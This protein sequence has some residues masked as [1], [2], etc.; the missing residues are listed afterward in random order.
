[1]NF[2]KF[3]N[4]E[5]KEDPKILFFEVKLT[6]ISFRVKFT[7]WEYRSYRSANFSMCIQCITTFTGKKQTI[8]VT[9][10]ILSCLLKSA[11]A[12]ILSLVNH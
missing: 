1:M 7:F 11:S 8:S 4:L 6:E 10:K 2:S 5:T 12:S 9:L 3:R